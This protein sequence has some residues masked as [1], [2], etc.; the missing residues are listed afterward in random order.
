MFS[1]ELETSVLQITHLLQGDSGTLGLIA[2]NR[3]QLDVIT[4][5]MGD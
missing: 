5:S 3:A 1:Q 2:V 4:S